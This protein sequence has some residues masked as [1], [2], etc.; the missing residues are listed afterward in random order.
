MS[1]TPESPERWV[2]ERILDFVN[3]VQTA[4]E[5]AAGVQDDP[6]SGGSGSIG[7][8]VAQR[9]LDARNALPGN[10]FR[11]FS[12]LDD[13]PGVGEDKINDLAYTFG[14][15]AA[16]AFQDRMYNGV[17]Y[18]ENFDLDYRSLSYATD[19]EFLA[20]V[21]NDSNFTNAV[22]A[23]VEKWVDERSG[24]RQLAATAGRYL[25]LTHLERTTSAHLG[26]YYFA[27][28][29]FRFDEDNWFSFE[30]VR[31]E[32]DF[33]LSYNPSYQDRLE[34]RFFKGFDNCG[35]LANAI[36]PTDLPAV[37]NYGERKITVWRGDLRD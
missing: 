36:S 13:V 10:R 33:Y 28:W 25:R 5:L 20:I 16:K 12:Q 4:A 8:T 18:R 22:G 27:Y 30:R 6:N 19:A 11:E 37:V 7:A 14:T 2:Q 3:R 24:N 34:L 32:T 21:D 9:I 31:T 23:V 17:I 29:F 26:G 15:P 35:L 1:T